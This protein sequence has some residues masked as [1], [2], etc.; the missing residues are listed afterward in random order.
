M[1]DMM[2]YLWMVLF[3]NTLVSCNTF[4]DNNSAKPSKIKKSSVATVVPDTANI[5]LRKPI[6]YDSTKKYIY[7]TFDDG[8]QHGT[9]ACLH[10]VKQLNVKA[11]FFMVAGNAYDTYL[12]EIVKN[13]RNSYPQILLGNHSYSHANNNYFYFYHHPE[14]AAADFFQTQ[15]ILNVPY[16]IIRMPG[17]SAWVGKN[18][19]KASHLVKPVCELLDSAGYNVIG[20]DVEW[21][22]NHK[23]ANPVQSPEKM[24]AIVDSA[25]ARNHTHTKN[26]LVILSHDRMFRNQNYTDSL[27]KFIEL[28]KQ[29]RDYVFETVDHYPNL[30]PL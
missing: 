21:G 16:K 24:M 18:N 28:L 11:T 25:F 5:F 19:M 6:T 3:L 20:W 13:V 9:T 10:L 17:N 14:M 15:Q 2:G 27:H 26:H 7:L 22:F 30:K 8:P 1:E 12:R 23:T 29:H 4:T